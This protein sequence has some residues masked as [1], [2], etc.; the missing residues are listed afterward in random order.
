MEGYEDLIFGSASSLR[1]VR[2]PSGVW[3]AK[4]FTAGDGHVDVRSWFVLSLYLFSRYSNIVKV[5]TKMKF[6]LVL[7]ICQR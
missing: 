6:Q 3:W 5:I 1:L 4:N 7:I 2:M